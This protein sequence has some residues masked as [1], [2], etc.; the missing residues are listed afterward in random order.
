MYEKCRLKLSVLAVFLLLLNFSME[1]YAFEGKFS[2]ETRYTVCFTPG[3]NC[4]K[5]ITDLIN[6][7]KKEI[8]VQGYSFTSAPIAKSLSEAKKR[9]IVVRVILDKSQKTQKYSGL[10]YLSN[11]GIPVWI[12]YRPAIAHNKILIVDAEIVQT[13]SFNY[14]NAAQ[15]RNAE[16]IIIIQDKQ[17]AGIYKKNW[18]KRLSSAILGE[19][20][21]HKNNKRNSKL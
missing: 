5:E 16:N 21:K 14:T 12:D 17:L 9:G 1:S 3:E 7:A 20:Y 11:N 8:L 2:P 10:T 18:E 6:S 4:T 13:G 19:D 15:K